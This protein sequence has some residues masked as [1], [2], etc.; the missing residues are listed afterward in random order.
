MKLSTGSSEMKLS[1]VRFGVILTGKPQCIEES[2]NT[3]SS[4]SYMYTGSICVLR[5]Y[6]HTHMQCT[7][8][9]LT[10]STYMLTYYLVRD[11]CTKYKNEELCSIFINIM[12]FSK[13]TEDRFSGLADS[14]GNC[15]MSSTSSRVYTRYN[16]S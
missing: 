14:P 3:V 11:T 9:L 10:Y 1:T 7:V 8:I 4:H 2:I 13:K 6:M 16:K 15:T 5:M 12:L